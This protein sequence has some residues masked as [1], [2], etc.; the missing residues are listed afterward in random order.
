[1]WNSSHGN[2][3]CDDA[4][5]QQKLRLYHWY[6]T[7][8]LGWLDNFGS[9]LDRLWSLMLFISKRDSWRIELKDEGRIRNNRWWGTVLAKHPDQISHLCP[10]GWLGIWCIGTWWRCNLQST[11]AQYGN[12]SCCGIFDWYVHDYVLYC[13]FKHHIYRIQDTK[14][15]LR[16]LDWRM[17]RSCFYYWALHPKQSRQKVR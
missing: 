2:G 5:R 6:L 8:Q 16:T 10:L 1:V 7:M 15:L 3:H 17:V 9:L 11:S 4:S 12:T 13:R 14:H